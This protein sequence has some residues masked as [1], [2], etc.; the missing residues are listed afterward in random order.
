MSILKYEMRAMFEKKTDHNILDDEII[1]QIAYLSF[2]NPYVFPEQKWRVLCVKS[3][4][5]KNKIFSYCTATQDTSDAATIL[6]FLSDSIIPENKSNLKL[7]N[8]SL[9]YACLLNQIDYD[10]LRIKDYQKLK[11]Y[12]NIP[13]NSNIQE[14]VSLGY[15]KSTSYNKKTVKYDDAVK[16]V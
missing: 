15:Y 6:I 1:R 4:L 8:I 5:S 7:L 14:I 13:D 2:L 11:D 3:S 10:L 12:F 16:E 9:M